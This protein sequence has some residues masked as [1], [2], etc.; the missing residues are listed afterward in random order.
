VRIEVKD[1]LLTARAKVA[2]VEDSQTKNSTIHVSTTNG[3]VTIVGQV[4]SKATAQRAQE[5]VARN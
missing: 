4:D 5:V 2:L 1:S 3:L